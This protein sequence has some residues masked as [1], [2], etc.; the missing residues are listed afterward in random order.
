[1]RSLGHAWSLASTKFGETWYGEY[2]D[3]DGHRPTFFILRYMGHNGLF[4][5]L[6][7]PKFEWVVVWLD[8][9]MNTQQ[10]M[11][12]KDVGLHAQILSIALK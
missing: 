3:L 7:V 1:M 9:R 6:D 2:R 4:I 11:C 5:L 12:L 8:L 10:K